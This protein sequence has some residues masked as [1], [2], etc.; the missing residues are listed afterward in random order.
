MPFIEWNEN[1]SVHVPSV[2]RQHRTLIKY[3]NELSDAVE[4]GNSQALVGHILKGLAG[5]T[6]IH[7]AY[8][9]MLFKS[10]NYPE[11]DDHK[12]VHVKLL[13]KVTTFGDRFERGET[14][15]GPELLAFLKRWLNHHILGDD[16]AYSEFMRKHG[17]Q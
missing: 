4:R 6:K 13:E 3:I 2:D 16:M 5:Y 8:E 7:F 12:T 1:L 9:E 17:V 14:D 11:T 15:I 10:Y